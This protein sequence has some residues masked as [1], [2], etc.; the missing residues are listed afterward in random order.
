[1]ESSAG[2]D[3]AHRGVLQRTLGLRARKPREGPD[4]RLTAASGASCVAGIAATA[5]T[6]L[7][8][9]EFGRFAAIVPLLAFR[10]PRSRSSSR[11]SGEA[12]RG[13]RG[14]GAGGSA[15][16][17]H[18]LRDAT[19]HDPAGRDHRRRPGP[20]RLRAHRGLGRTHGLPADRLPDIRAF[21]AEERGLVARNFQGIVLPFAGMWQLADG[22]TSPQFYHLYP[23]LMAVAWPV[24][25]SGRRSGQ[26]AAQ[27]RRRA[28]AVCAC[29]AA[30]RARWALAAAIVH[31]LCCAQIRQA[32]F[33]PPR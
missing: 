25:A 30:P 24:G 29:R 18:R 20:G 12:R 10:R 32:K 11:C 19:L 23:S 14:G 7:T 5:W 2:A 6:A 13:S 28:R 16:G 17:R 1:M 9:A 4:V 15:R 3:P 33:P 27:R 8:L 26:P 22:R 21:T 31:A